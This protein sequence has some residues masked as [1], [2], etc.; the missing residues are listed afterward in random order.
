MARRQRLRMQWQVSQPAS[1]P[2]SQVSH[3]PTHPLTHSLTH[4]PTH[5]LTHSLTQQLLSLPSL[6]LPTI[7]A[8]SGEMEGGAA[9]AE[10]GEVEGGVVDTAAGWEARA[11]DGWL[12]SQL[13][14]VPS[15]LLPPVTS[16]CTH[17]IRQA[18]RPAPSALQPRGSVS[19]LR[20]LVRIAAARNGTAGALKVTV[21]EI[22]PL[23]TRRFSAG[24][25]K[26]ME[27]KL[28]QIVSEVPERAAEARAMEVEA[29]EAAEAAEADVRVTGEV[30]VEVKARKKARRQVEV[31]GGEGGTEVCEAEVAVESGE[32]GVTAPPP[33]SLG[34]VSTVAG[35]RDAAGSLADGGIEAGCAALATGGLPVGSTVAAVVRDCGGAAPLGWSPCMAAAEAAAAEA[36]AAA[37]GG[38]TA[39]SKRRRG[40]AAVDGGSGGLSAADAA[41][42]AAEAYAEAEMSEL[43]AWLVDTPSCHQQRLP[44]ASSPVQSST[45]A[46]GVGSGPLR[47]EVVA[48]T[49]AFERAGLRVDGHVGVGLAPAARAPALMSAVGQ[50]GA[51]WQEVC[52]RRRSGAT[53]PSYLRAC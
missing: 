21:S 32:G 41:F 22:T 48:A 47:D 29:A 36:A 26:K 42:W 39:P 4:S 28:R 2:V 25:G 6:L 35:G 12:S 3:P 1:Q 49:I 34:V 33:S 37:G 46:V 43:S 53:S 44:A 7:V 13:S 20:R 51:D 18:T 50:H 11:V 14:S 38:S 19:E 10:G 16:I 5:P 24:G 40:R 15:H 30:E 52:L 9:A 17:V 23:L 31:V 45:P 8:V 27:R